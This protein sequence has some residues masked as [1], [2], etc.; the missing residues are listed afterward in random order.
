MSGAVPSVPTEYHAGVESQ[1]HELAPSPEGEILTVAFLL[2]FEIL[3]RLP[4]F[5]FAE[6][7]FV[8]N[9]FARHQE[10][11]YFFD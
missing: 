8:G 10:F 5:L 9:V 7:F 3:W 6:K 1:V 4:V 11:A 2:N